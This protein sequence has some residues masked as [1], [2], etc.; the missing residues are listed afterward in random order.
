MQIDKKKRTWAVE[1]NKEYI[2]GSK[3]ELLPDEEAD[4]GARV[5]AILHQCVLLQEGRECRPSPVASTYFNWDRRTDETSSG[6]DDE[7]RPTLPTDQP[8][9]RLFPVE[10]LEEGEKGD[11]TL[12]RGGIG[13]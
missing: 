13:N 7:H 8:N 1:K 10:T 3:K 6:G 2:K 11:R 12:I 4:E 5:S 9:D